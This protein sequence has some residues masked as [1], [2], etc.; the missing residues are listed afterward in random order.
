MCVLMPVPH[1]ID[2]CS[3]VVNFEIGKYESANFVLF[4]DYS[5]SSGALAFSKETFLE[6]DLIF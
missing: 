6:I 2:Y 5:G 3:F 4:Q 1:C